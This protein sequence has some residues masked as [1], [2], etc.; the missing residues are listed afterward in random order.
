MITILKCHRCSRIFV[1]YGERKHPHCPSTRCHTMV[2]KN[3]NTSIPIMCLKN[4]G[5][6]SIMPDRR[7]NQAFVMVKAFNN[8]VSLIADV[9]SDDGREF[10]TI[11]LNTDKLKITIQDLISCIPVNCMKKDSQKKII[12]TSGKYQVNT[13]LAEQI[14]GAL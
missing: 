4:F 9:Y 13:K 3:K 1:Y 12:F 8:E 2:T 6:D 7:S 5:P 11:P 10:I 14:E